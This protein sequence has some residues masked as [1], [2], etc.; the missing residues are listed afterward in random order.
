M[1]RIPAIRRAILADVPPLQAFGWSVVAVAVPTLVR[2]SIGVGATSGL[3]F[4]TYYPAVMLA[5]L[6]LGWRWGAGVAVA[7]GLVANWLFAGHSGLWTFG[8]DDALREAMFGLSCA[9]LIWVG[10]MCR[11]LVRELEQSKARE[12][13]LNEELMHRVK[14]MLATVN[15]LAT[16]T[17]RHSSPAEFQAALSGRM[18]ALSRATDLLGVGQAAQCDI[19]RLVQHAV[20]AFRTSTNFTLEGPA[21]ELPRDAC[22]PLSLALHELCTNAAKYGALSRP[23]GR[24]SLLWTVGEGADGLLRLAWREEGGPPVETPTKVGMGTQLLRRQGALSKVDV[25]F[26][27]TGLCCDIEIEGVAA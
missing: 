5:G 16:L 20:E 21:S 19:H 8:W 22:V 6:L 10:E 15:A 14:N 17:A 24:V 11:R 23:E 18:R 1:D 25:R 27:P 26:E 12:T 13:L 9:V 7:S 2:W 3:T 4:S